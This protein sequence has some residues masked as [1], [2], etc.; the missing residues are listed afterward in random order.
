ME[1][2]ERIVLALERLAA[3]NE[4]IVEMANE[5]RQANYQGGPPFCPHC[6]T[7][8]PT[9]KNNG[10]EGQMGEFILVAVCGN[11]KELFYAVPEGWQCHRT[12]EEVDQN[13]G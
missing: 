1:H 11:C 12:R 9:V 7:F 2:S 13:G 10:G 6:G 4:A 3:S 8:N 5:E